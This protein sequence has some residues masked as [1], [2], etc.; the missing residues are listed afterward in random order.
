MSRVLVWFSC[1]AA[2]AVAAKNEGVDLLSIYS[3]VIGEG[4]AA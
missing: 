2:S 1:V 3:E 4:D